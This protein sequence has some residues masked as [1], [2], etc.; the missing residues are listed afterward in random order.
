[1]G[2]LA[3]VG[4]TSTELSSS[5][6]TSEGRSQVTASPT[7]VE[8]LPG[9]PW[10]L[11]AWYLPGKQTKNLFLVR[12]DGTDSHVILSGLP[13]EHMAASWS[14]DGS[15]FAFTNRDA[16]TP[17]GS[18]WTANADGSG[19]ELL[20]DGG[21]ECPDGIFHPTWSPDASKLS[22]ICYPDPGGKEG[23][24][25]TFDLATGQVTRLYTVEW[26]EHL[27]GPADWSPDGSSLAFTIY[28]WDPTD[29]FVD[30]S[31]VAM[32]PAAGGTVRRLTTFAD[33][34]TEGSWSPDG[35]EIAVAKNDVGMRH[36]SD[37]A[38]NVYAIAPDGTGLRQIT[39]SSVDGY[40]RIFAP[41][42][43]PDGRMMVNVGLAPHQ[44]GVEA[45]VNDLR[46]GFVDPSG[47]EPVLLPPTIHGGI[48]R[49][50]PAD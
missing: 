10:I 47:G 38:S 11:S 25:A 45:T 13:G 4:C 9:E 42:W 24:V 37:Q 40:M 17:G 12:P 23:S 49:P 46:V 18:I 48:L 5:S 41:E 2:S 31:L 29:Q 22:V 8:V 19:A 1:M 7:S 26:P 21:G 32:I 14:P 36:S 34:L 6:T 43:G 28:H 20:T 27:D 15:R 39:K 33:D 35:S 3:I 16:A 44:A 30:G 50:T